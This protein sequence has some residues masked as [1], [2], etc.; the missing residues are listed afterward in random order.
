ML[1]RILPEDVKTDTE[2]MLDLFDMLCLETELGEPG[3]QLWLPVQPRRGHVD[4]PVA[5]NCGRRGVVH[6]TRLEDD[7]DVGGQVHPVP[8][9]Q[10]QDLGVVEHRVEVL[11]PYG[12]HRAVQNEPDVLRLSAVD[13]EGFPP[14]S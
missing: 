14:E 4:H 6:V 5:G 10:G 11:Y 8:V 9:G 12:V 2:E 13:L 3:L 1:L 7:L